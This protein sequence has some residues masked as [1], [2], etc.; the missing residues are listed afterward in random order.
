SAPPEHAGG[1]WR[2]AARGAPDRLTDQTMATGY[3]PGLGGGRPPA[4][5]PERVRVPLQPAPIPQPRA[6]LLPNTP[7]RHRPRPSALSR[8]GPQ[9]SAQ[10]DTTHPAWKTGI[11]T[12][13]GPPT[14]ASTMANH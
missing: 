3:P 6:G 14:S 4:Q 13:H 8:P 5:L 2:A 12:K 7:A 1:P 10:D 9:P 11:S